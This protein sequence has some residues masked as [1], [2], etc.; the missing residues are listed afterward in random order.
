MQAKLIAYIRPYWDRG[1]YQIVFDGE[2]SNLP[3]N[4]KILFEISTTGKT[5]EVVETLETAA[6]KTTEAKGI[7]LPFN[8]RKKPK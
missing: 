4:A 5:R 3:A 7:K 1:E 6:E 2:K 8:R